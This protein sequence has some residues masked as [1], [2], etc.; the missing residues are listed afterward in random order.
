[1]ATP[2]GDGG[3]RVRTHELRGAPMAK[4]PD[5]SSPLNDI[6]ARLQKCGVRM[7]AVDVAFKVIAFI[8]LTPLVTVLMRTLLALSGNAVVSDLDILYFCLGPIGWLTTLLVG[9]FWLGI[10]ALEQATLLGV[11]AADQAGKPLQM[12]TA[13][14]FAAGKAWPLVRVTG[15]MVG[16]AL[17][18]VAP[19]LAIAGLVYTWLLSDYD[20]NYYLKEK[21]P[22]FRW[23]LGLAAVLVAGIA[24]VVLRLCTSWFLAL[25]LVLFEGVDPRQALSASR[26][27]MQGHRRKLLIWIVSWFVATTLLSSL[28][29][30]VVGGLGRWMTP[31][32]T[33]SLRMLTLT[34]G[35]TLVLWGVANLVI[36]L[37]S[38]TSF[39]AMIFSFYQ[40]I[41]TPHYVDTL[42]TDFEKAQ[43]S[44]WG[45]KVTR[46]RI[47][48]A[49]ALGL[50]VAFGVGAFTL[51]SVPM[52]DHT[53]V[54]AHRGASKGAPENTMASFRQAIDDQA[55]WIE[56]DVQ[57]TADG[58]VVVMHDSDFMRL[59]NNKRNVWDST[60][61]ELAD[62]DIGSWFDAKF[63][64]ERVV[65]LAQVLDECR[66]RVG[67]IIELKYYG[68]DQQLEQRVAELVEARGM[69]DQVMAMSL[70]R[71][72][73][74]QMKSLRPEWKVGLLMSVAAGDLK[75]LDI[76]FVA[77]NARFATRHLIRKAHSNGQQVFVW[78][79]NDAATM[80]AMISRGVDGL[81]TDRPALARSVLSQRAEM[82]VAERL[83]LEFSSIFGVR[84]EFAEQ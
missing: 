17:L 82:S 45:L 71:S 62:I 2:M 75:K 58:V 68:H 76:D 8:V 56:L 52:E 6:F 47:L 13:L 64:S 40:R 18:A 78:T 23:A 3:Q 32:A 22:E 29:T 11:L 25:P 12:F 67:V 84:A 42:R 19:F 27:R 55:D 1:M 31:E 37:L 43:A 28:A 70:K 51:Q 81:L 72:Q 66:D 61:A 30:A 34:V 38:T 35:L 39:A 15:R 59:A 73:V 41:E 49:A 16:F 57:E 48:V 9:A 44:S 36:N 83:L 46:R 60:T 80:S 14:R 20:I 74:E 7:A 5:S 26:G 54:M 63:Q 65:T 21:P 69:T 10:L 53:E 24:A 77:V 33:T 4:Q 79:V 50:L